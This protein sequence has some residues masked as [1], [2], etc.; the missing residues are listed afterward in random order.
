MAD[1]LFGDLLVLGAQASALAE[2]VRKKV[3]S[4]ERKRKVNLWAD[5][6]LAAL[7]E[8]AELCEHPVFRE[9]IAEEVKHRLLPA[10]YALAAACAD[11]LLVSALAG[12]FKALEKPSLVAEPEQ[13]GH[14]P[15]EVGHVAA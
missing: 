4:A 13:L 15:E 6:A 11:Q 7:E 8:L 3:E 10:F 12:Y 1:V 2:E 5:S 14:Y 9:L